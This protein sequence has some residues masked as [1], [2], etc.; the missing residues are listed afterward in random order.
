MLSVKQEW[1]INFFKRKSVHLEIDTDNYK[2]ESSK[3]TLYGEAERKP[4]K[5]L[6]LLPRA[7]GPVVTRIDPAI[8]LGQTDFPINIISFTC[9]HCGIY[10]VLG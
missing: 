6:L 5:G 3:E 7:T 8:E 4:G 10:M 2:S 1:S 9:N